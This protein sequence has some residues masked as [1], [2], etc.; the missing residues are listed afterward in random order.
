MPDKPTDS[1]I[2]HCALLGARKLFDQ[3]V[4][5]QTP[6]PATGDDWMSKVCD[7][8]DAA[9][10][11]L[12]KPIPEKF[13]IEF[14]PAAGATKSM[15]TADGSFAKRGKPLPYVASVGDLKLLLSQLPDELELESE[16]REPHWYNIGEPD[17]CLALEY[18]EDD[19]DD[20]FDEDDD[21][22]GGFDNIDDD[23]FD[24]DDDDD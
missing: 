3:G 10:Q 19:D 2:L 14:E 12:V 17:E 23:A 4:V 15:Y 18:H 13:K 21:L 5:V 16:N 1:Q 24:E 22:D 7:D 8:I 11:I 20:D 6:I 9:I